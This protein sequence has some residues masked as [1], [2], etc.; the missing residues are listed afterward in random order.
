MPESTPLHFPFSTWPCLSS[1]MDT[2]LIFRK[3]HSCC[4]ASGHRAGPENRR[5]WNKKS[6]LSAPSQHSAGQPPALL[7]SGG[8][9][10]HSYHHQVSGCIWICELMACFYPSVAFRHAARLRCFCNSLKQEELSRNQC[11]FIWNIKGLWGWLSHGATSQEVTCLQT[12]PHGPLCKPSLKGRGR[13]WL[14]TSLQ[15]TQAR[16]WCENKCRTDLPPSHVGQ[17]PQLS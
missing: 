8:G 11:V 3:E 7:G 14:W 13:G 1:E 5:Q 16:G 17:G 2:Y 15:G 6:M 10:L 9:G 12:A 4:Y